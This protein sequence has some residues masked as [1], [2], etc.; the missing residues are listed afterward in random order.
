[1][2]ND[3]VLDDAVEQVAADETELAVYGGQGA[4]DVGPVFGVV[5][6]DVHVGVVQ[7]GDGN[8]DVH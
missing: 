1:M 8:C 7:V 4:F 5:V 2:V 3:V 6:G